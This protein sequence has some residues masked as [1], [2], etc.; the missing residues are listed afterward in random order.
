MGKMKYNNILKDKQGHY[1]EIIS[2]KFGLFKC[3]IDEE[4]I[5]LVKYFT[6]NIQEQPK[7]KGPSTFYVG[8]HIK[9]DGKHYTLRIHRLLMNPPKG[10]DVDHINQDPLN[11]TRANLR[12]VTRQQNC[13]NTSAKGYYFDKTKQ[14]YRAAIAAYGKRYHLGLFSTEEE[15]REAYLEAKEIYHKI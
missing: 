1:I 3:Y 12:I 15:A 5:D 13:F 7:K 9:N 4:D 2:P 8:T 6:W 10:M 14:K 11:N